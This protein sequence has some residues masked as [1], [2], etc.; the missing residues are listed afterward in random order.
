MVLFHQRL[1]FRL[2]GFKRRVGA[3]PHYLQRLALGIEHL[4]G[5]GLGLGTGPGA[6]PPPAA[7]VEFAEH[8]EWI[9]RAFQVGLG[10]ALALFG[11]GIC[12]HLPGRAV[13][14]QC[15]LLIARD[16]IRIHAL[17]EIIGLVVL[18]HVIETEVPIF[19]GVGAA[20]GRAMRRLVLAIRP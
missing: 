1:V 13:P 6:R 15:I 7:A 14:G 3:K 4:S 19:L 12:A 9:G 5:F 2:H 17:E 8:A 18:A 20:L 16:R 10:A 11:A